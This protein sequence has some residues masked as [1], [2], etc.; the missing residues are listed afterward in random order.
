MLLGWPFDNIFFSDK[1]QLYLFAISVVFTD[2]P[3]INF[4]GCTCRE[5][6][7]SPCCGTSEG[8][9]GQTIPSCCR[10]TR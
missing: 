5:E 4:S 3:C 2:F 6:G 9:S 8:S 7:T 1:R 10:E